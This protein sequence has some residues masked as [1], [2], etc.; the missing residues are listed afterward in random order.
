[1]ALQQPPPAERPDR[2]RIWS[3]V[4]VAGWCAMPAHGNP[5]NKFNSCGGLIGWDYLSDMTCVLEIGRLQ[6]LDDMHADMML[7]PPQA[8]H[9]LHVFVSPTRR[10]RLCCRGRAASGV[11]SKAALDHRQMCVARAN[12]TPAASR[13]REARENPCDHRTWKVGL[14]QAGRNLKLQ[15]AG[16]AH[17]HQ[18]AS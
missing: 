17:N 12:R 2:V 14:S 9:H 15:R 18:Q 7:Q 6:A 10:R 11:K 3:H 16:S 13:L 5:F 4:C 8:P 1:M